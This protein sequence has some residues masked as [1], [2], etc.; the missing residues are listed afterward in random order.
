MAEDPRAVETM[1][2]KTVEIDL[3]RPPVAHLYLNLPSR[4]NALS[5]DSFAE[6]SAAISALD[7]HPDVLAVVVS[8]RGTQ[9]CSGIDLSALETI[10][11]SAG[12]TATDP[13]RSRERLRRQIL[14]LQA[15]LSAFEG[16]RKPVLA[17]VDGSCIG[18]GVDLVS[19]CDLRYCTRAA[20]FVVKEVDLAIA[21]DLGTL[22][23]LP[24][25]VGYGNA[26][27]MALTARSVSAAEAKEM[28]LVSRV[29]DSREE[30]EVGVRAIAEEIC[31][32]S[33]MAVM[34]T[35]AVLLKSRDV[36]VEQGLDYAATWNSG[37]LI[38]DDLQEAIKAFI[39]KRKPT[40]AK[41]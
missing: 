25:I 1:K 37:M 5:L 26:A 32:K 22:Q 40:F 12:S 2:F 10:V 38:S 19:A 36:S 24:R 4:R 3:N 9:F 11:S 13:G 7:R 17:A 14:S 6:I 31:K 23:R 16:C 15:A 27:E 20:S 35:K 28:G 21:A 34:G 41:L 18:A 33:P 30:M 29:F 39:Q 8:G